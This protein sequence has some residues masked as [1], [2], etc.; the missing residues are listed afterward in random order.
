MECVSQPSHGVQRHSSVCEHQRLGMEEQVP[1]HPWYHG[2]L[3]LLGGRINSAGKFKLPSLCH[4]GLGWMLQAVWGSQSPAV[5]SSWPWISSIQTNSVPAQNHKPCCDLFEISPNSL[6][7]I[8]FGQREQIWAPPVP[9]QSFPQ[10]HG[11]NS[12]VN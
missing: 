4:K 11:Q 7:F 3:F 12:L 5:I 6:R 1:T 8:S 9:S 10:Q 2:W